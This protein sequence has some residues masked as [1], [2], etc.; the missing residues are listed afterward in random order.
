MVLQSPWAN[1]VAVRSGATG[2]ILPR[3]IYFWLAALRAEHIAG[4]RAWEYQFSGDHFGGA[5]MSR[6]IELFTESSFDA[7]AVT[8]LCDAYDRACTTLRNTG[9]PEIVNEV[10]A[11]QIIAIARTG[12]R[13]PERLCE[14]ALKAAFPQ[15]SI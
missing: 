11:Q 2:A 5:N 9:Q 13:D 6:V 4:P 1:T 8:V 10:L 14:R 15:S 7:E 12:E 3:P